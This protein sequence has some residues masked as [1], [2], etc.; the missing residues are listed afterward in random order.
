MHQTRWPSLFQAVTELSVIKP[1]SIPSD[2]VP[3]TEKL[4][5]SL[6]RTQSCQRFFL[7]LEVRI[8][9]CMLDLLPGILLFYFLP[10]Q[11][12]SVFPLSISCKEQRDETFTCG[13][14]CFCSVMTIWVD[15]VL[16]SK[17]Q[18]PLYSHGMCRC[19]LLWDQS[20]GNCFETCHA[21]AWGCWPSKKKRKKKRI[22]T[23]REKISSFVIFW[24]KFKFCIGF[25]NWKYPSTEVFMLI[26]KCCS[27]KT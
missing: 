27:L 23:K 19:L 25:T 26:F 12:I 15:W 16:N 18:S 7:C 9:L 3:Q 10:S 5:S 13:E 21:R 6:Q 2:E 8:S 4:T 11:S 22:K 14:F 1:P 17:C 20:C 24:P